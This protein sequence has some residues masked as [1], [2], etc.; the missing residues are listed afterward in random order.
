MALQTRTQNRPARP[1]NAVVTQ[2]YSTTAVTVPA[3][4]A[5][6]LT[7]SDGAG[8]NDG[9]IGAITGDASVI[10]A[11]QEIAAQ[12]AKLVADD[13]ALRKTQ[14]LIIDVLQSEGIL[15]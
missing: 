10:A 12:V 8:T 15:S 1:A 3:A 5:A 7:V 4:T 9:T 13:L 11:V 14:N 6:A 2:T